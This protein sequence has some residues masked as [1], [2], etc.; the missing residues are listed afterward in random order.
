VRAVIEFVK[1]LPCLCHEELE[2]SIDL[3][4]R[5]RLVEVA[6]KGCPC[7]GYPDCGHKHNDKS[8]K[9]FQPVAKDKK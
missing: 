2:P 7:C 6:L 8:V 1:N 3:C 9:G 4:D 5:C